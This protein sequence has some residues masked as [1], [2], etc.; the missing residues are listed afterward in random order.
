[1]IL[2]QARVL[3]EVRGTP[4]ECRGAGEILL[5]AETD[6]WADIAEGALQ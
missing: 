6:T 4:R 3:K 1:M 5:E 2:G